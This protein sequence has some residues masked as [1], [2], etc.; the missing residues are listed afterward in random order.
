MTALRALLTLTF[1][2]IAFA[3]GSVLVWQVVTV[4][5]WFV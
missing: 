4:Y 1:L 2:S 5:R 3:A